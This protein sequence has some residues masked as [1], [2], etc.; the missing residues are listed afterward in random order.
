MWYLSQSIWLKFKEL[1]LAAMS[2]D[3]DH[4]QSQFPALASG[5]IFADNAGG[6][7][8]CNDVINR[9]S[10]YLSSTNVQLGADYAVSQKST[11][12]VAD[13]AIAAKEL[14]NAV[15][16]N[17][18]AFSSSSTLSIENLARAMESDIKEGDEFI[19]TGEH[20]GA[21]LFYYITERLLITDASE[22]RAM[23]EISSSQ[24]RRH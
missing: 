2:L 9:I 22:C 20:E 23:E 18:I 6:T 7:Q 4:V 3:I 12:R 1:T 17:E 15:S 14:F 16:E 13:G 21:S 10:D 8:V 11:Q 24:R 5:Y 19:I